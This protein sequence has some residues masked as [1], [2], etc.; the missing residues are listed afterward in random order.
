MRFLEREKA[1]DEYYGSREN[2]SS[3]MMAQ[4]ALDYS[5]DEPPVVVL[6]LGGIDLI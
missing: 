6:N 2:R 3:G 5:I 4:F 1:I